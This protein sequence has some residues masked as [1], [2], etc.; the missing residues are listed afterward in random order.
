MSDCSPPRDEYVDNLRHTWGLL[1]SDWAY[2]RAQEWYTRLSQERVYCGAFG[3]PGD[4]LT[5][6]ACTIMVCST[7]LSNATE[8]YDI[9]AAEDSGLPYVGLSFFCLLYTSPSPR[10]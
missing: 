1:D 10:D 9:A 5:Q 7:G 6:Y 8:Q 3:F 2:A 4:V